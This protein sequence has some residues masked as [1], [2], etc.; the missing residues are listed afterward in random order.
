MSVPSP[1]VTQLIEDVLRES[2]DGKYGE[3]GGWVN[4]NHVQNIIANSGRWPRK[5]PYALDHPSRPTVMKVLRGLHAQ[6]Q[7]ERQMRHPYA[8]WRRKTPESQTFMDRFPGLSE[9]QKLAGMDLSNAAEVY[10]GGAEKDGDEA[11]VD[12][13]YADVSGTLMEIRDLAGKL[14]SEVSRAYAAWEESLDA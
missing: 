9:L 4:V 3:R 7:V 11:E 13:L 5:G 14:S 10:I 2:L 8:Y 6:G 1:E 12:E